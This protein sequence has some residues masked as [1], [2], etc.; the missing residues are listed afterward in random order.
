MP[1]VWQFSAG[2]K[3][4]KDNVFKATVSF[5][6]GMTSTFIQVLKAILFFNN[7]GYMVTPRI[8]DYLTYDNN[9]YKTLWWQTRIC[10]L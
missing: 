4:K 8:V 1:K 3:D 10:N 6:Q 2:D 7:D 9:K 5:G